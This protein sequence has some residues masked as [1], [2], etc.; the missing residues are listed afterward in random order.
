MKK[1][2]HRLKPRGPY[3]LVA[4][5]AQRVSVEQPVRRAATTMKI[6]SEVQSV[7]GVAL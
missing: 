3:S 1:L 5:A 2:G 4:G 6:G 7:H